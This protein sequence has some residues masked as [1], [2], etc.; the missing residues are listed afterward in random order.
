M[1][2]IGVVNVFVLA[3][4]AYGVRYIGYSFITCAW[5]AFPFEALEVLR[6]THSRI[7]LMVTHMKRAD[8]IVLPRYSPFT[9][10]EWPRSAT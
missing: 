8:V 6:I 9:C 7:Q 4:A 10:C 5:L 3:L 2:R 1:R